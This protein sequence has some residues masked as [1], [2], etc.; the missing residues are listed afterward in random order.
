MYD[1]YF[2]DIPSK[3]KSHNEGKP[4]LFLPKPIKNKIL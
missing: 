3:I 2:I 1:W 4:V